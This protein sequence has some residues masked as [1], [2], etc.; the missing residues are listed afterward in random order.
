[1]GGKVDLYL[2]WVAELTRDPLYIMGE[3]SPNYAA[4]RNL[5]FIISFT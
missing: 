3:E 4:L 5:S 1:M 2:S